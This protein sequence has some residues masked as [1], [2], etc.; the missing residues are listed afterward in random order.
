MK[1]RF[2]HISMI[3]VICGFTPLAGYYFGKN[4]VHEH[5][6]NWQIL[7]STHF[8]IY[9]DAP[10]SN[11]ALRAAEIAEQA[12]ARHSDLLAAPL[13]GIV[14][15]IIFNNVHDFANNNI[16]DGVLDPG[17]GGYTE[18]LR[19]RVA[20]PFTGEYPVFYHVLVHELVHAFQI[21]IYSGGSDKLSFLRAG[22]GM[23][24]LWVMEGLAEYG[25]LGRDTEMEMYARDG[26]MNGYLPTLRE[27]EDLNNIGYKYF[28]I[29]KGGQA[30]FN[31][32][33]KNYGKETAADILHGYKTAR[34]TDAVFN[35]LTGKDAE[36]ISR[37][38]FT[39]LKKEYWPQIGG[40]SDPEDRDLRLT[41]HFH[42]G[43]SFNLKPVF[44]KNDQTVALLTDR[45][46]YPRI[47]LIN[48][49]TGRREKIIAT[50]IKE[51]A[52]EDIRI[53]ENML[54]FDRSGSKLLFLAQQG[55]F[56]TLN[57]YNFQKH[58][59]VAI[60]K[61]DFDTVFSPQISPDGN[62][63]VFC[64]HK[65]GQI[66][67]YIY[68][69]TE[70]KLV[71]LTDDLFTEK[72]PAWSPDGKHIIYA[73]NANYA[74]Y[75]PQYDLFIKN[76][77]TG[78]T[79]LFTSSASQNLSP[80]W[81][82]DGSMIAFSSDRSGASDI[83]IKHVKTRELFRITGLIGG[84]FDPKWSGDGSRL[85]Y[86]AF[87]RG[88]YDVYIA[89]IN[90]HDSSCVKET[91]I[92][93]IDKKNSEEKRSYILK[94][95]ET[96]KSQ[97]DFYYQPENSN[98]ERYQ[99]SLKLE[100]IFGLMGV[101]SGSGAGGRVAMLFS[102]MLGDHR[103]GIDAYLSYASSKKLFDTDL[104]AEYIYLKSK[105][106]IGTVGFFQ[107]NHLFQYINGDFYDINNYAIL[108]EIQ[109][110]AGIFARYPF[111]VYNRCD[112]GFTPGVFSRQ[113]TA[114]K[115]EVSYQASTFTKMLWLWEFSLTHDSVIYGR[116]AP[117]DNN[118]SYLVFQASPRFSQNNFEFYK[119][120]F[121][122]RNYW[123]LW[124]KGGF[125]LRLMSGIVTGADRDDFRFRIGG[126][127][128]DDNFPNI[129]G[130]RINEFSGRI[131]HLFNVE[132]RTRFLEQMKLAF[133]FPLQ[134]A[135]I[136]GVIFFDAGSAYDD[137]ND[138]RFSGSR[139]RLELDTVKAGLGFGLRFVLFFLPCKID[140]S[141]PFTGYSVMPLRKWNGFFSIGYDF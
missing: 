35:N 42:D 7:K 12:S 23:P 124:R 76:P 112:L 69:I 99:A 141:T 131:M 134:I 118:R 57:I 16:H 97:F 115:N 126:A 123:M 125:A 80:A 26:I 50:A 91:M 128:L 18:F 48:S 68:S 31:F 86:S 63:I 111:S 107:Q 83:Y 43:S 110:G 82:P 130:Y 56:F 37:E 75:S 62:S 28:Y 90:L 98:K 9:Y 113:Y 70:K 74:I 108:R 132:Y 101:S 96:A 73:G 85:V 139:R 81:S 25:S 36:K 92:D 104:L 55:K 88:G 122:V 127:S 24:P 72:T 84:A 59:V 109:G 2:L 21:H 103:A 120:F 71:R 46:I 32:I 129:R 27:M 94:N 66:D 52:Y 22:A 49:K 78:E 14:P 61:L 6:Y 11:L 102:D 119:I 137:F 17:T 67:L 15:V 105:V 19:T 39:E 136:D 114:K 10:M 1:F 41:R 34:N 30:F 8:D 87:D 100:M 53:L 51:S 47:M 106:N 45:K 133:P 64:G 20:V 54:S 117:A 33:E 5:R 38:W 138:F 3:T 89:D 121:D 13:A 29:Y 77:E 116:T 95:S 58:R 40:R 93:G 79:S 60:I 65:N 140:F 4:K 135:N 44:G